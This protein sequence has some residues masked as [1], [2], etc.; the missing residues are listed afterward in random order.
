MMVTHYHKDEMTTIINM[1]LILLLNLWSW[2]NWFG[3]L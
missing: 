2:S 1:D 3:K